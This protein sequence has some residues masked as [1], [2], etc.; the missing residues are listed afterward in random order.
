LGG[1]RPSPVEDVVLGPFSR[2]FIRN[3]IAPSTTGT[4]ARAPRKIGPTADV[5]TTV[6]DDFLRSNEDARVLIARASGYDVN[7]IRFRNPFIPLLR[8]TIGAGVEIV[9]KHE[10]RHL[11]QAERVRQSPGF[12]PR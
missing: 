10:S 9:S 8:F 5:D 3:Y 11:L 4:R 12:P 2:W 7:R 6:L 1:Q